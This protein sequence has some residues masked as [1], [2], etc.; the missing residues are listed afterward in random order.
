MLIDIKAKGD[1]YYKPDI[2][3]KQA[4]FNNKRK[5]VSCVTI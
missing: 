5:D 1:I 2:R 3:W 4:V